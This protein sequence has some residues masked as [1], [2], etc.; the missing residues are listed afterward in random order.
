MTNRFRETGK[1][2]SLSLVALAYVCT[3]AGAIGVEHRL[4]LADSAI[5]AT[6]QIYEAELCTQDPDFEGIDGIRFKRQAT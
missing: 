3:A 1:A 4:P 2:V 6:A 5:L